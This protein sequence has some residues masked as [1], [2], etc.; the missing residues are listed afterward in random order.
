M[1]DYL[2]SFFK[3]IVSSLELETDDCKVKENKAYFSVFF[4][5]NLICTVKC[6]DK[7]NYISFS[8][9]HKKEF[10]N[11][12][13]CYSIPSDKDHFRILFY[14]ISELDNMTS[15]IANII[16]SVS[17]TKT[18][19]ICSYYM[20]CSDNKKC[21]N[22]NKSFARECRYKDKLEKGIIFYGKNRTV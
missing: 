6:G 14:D 19:D 9:A 5:E 17:C 7:T 8:V 18:F 13:S 4:S 10:E 1:L 2:D 16:K 22:P 20:E 21:V 11:L 15:Q 12:F 3:E